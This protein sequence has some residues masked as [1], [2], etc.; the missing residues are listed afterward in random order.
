MKKIDTINP[1]KNLQTDKML[2]VDVL[3]D[4]YAP[5]LY[6]LVIKLVPDQDV[7]EEII[8]QTFLKAYQNIAS[9]KKNDSIFCWLLKYAILC[10]GGICV[11][12]KL[13]EWL[14]AAR[15]GRTGSLEVFS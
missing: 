9:L 10:S 2:S 12:S 15:S 6:G 5:A 13:K 8:C 14:V 11:E 7:A 3:Y 1:G 4:R